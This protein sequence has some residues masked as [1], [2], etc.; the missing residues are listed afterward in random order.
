MSIGQDGKAPGQHHLQVIWGLELEEGVQAA[1]A[2]PK[3][4]RIL[5]TGVGTGP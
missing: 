3:D 2:S 1:R 4:D 5:S